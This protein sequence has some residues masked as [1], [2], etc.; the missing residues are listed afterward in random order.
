MG[1]KCLLRKEAR[2]RQ[3]SQP[4]PPA[5]THT[6][7][8]WFSKRHR[9]KWLRCIR[10]GDF[11]NK[12][13]NI[14]Q[15]KGQLRVAWSFLH[16]K[17]DFSQLQLFK[18]VDFEDFHQRLSNT[19]PFHFKAS[20]FFPSGLQVQEQYTSQLPPGLRGHIYTAFHF[21]KWALQGLPSAFCPWLGM[22]T[23]SEGKLKLFTYVC[24]CF[25]YPRKI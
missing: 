1:S 21:R 2:Q 10:M 16:H 12:K 9:L 19:Q 20:G 15:L 4:I 23:Q 11:C 24:K 17:Y 6:Q 18:F 14:K 8:K 3:D 13:V 25:F 7:K 5:P 22:F